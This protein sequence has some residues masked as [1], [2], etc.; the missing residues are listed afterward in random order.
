VSLQ[1]SIIPAAVHKILPQF[2]DLHASFCEKHPEVGIKHHLISESNV[3]LI[4]PVY[5]ASSFRVKRRG[6]EPQKLVSI[7]RPRKV[8]LRLYFDSKTG[9]RAAAELRIKNGRRVIDQLQFGDFV[10]QTYETV[11]RLRRKNRV[12]RSAYSL[13]L[14]QIPALYFSALWLRAKRETDFYVSLVSLKGSLRSGH[15]YNRSEVERALSVELLRRKE[16]KEQLL[17]RKAKS[18][19]ARI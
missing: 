7:G 18:M 14:L 11:R 15:I 5:V 4:L 3:K 1:T 19:A 6:P 8:A 13:C 9:V 16:A 2:L 12:H 17:V 10:R